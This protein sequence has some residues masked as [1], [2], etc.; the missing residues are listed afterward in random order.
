MAVKSISQHISYLLLTC[1]KVEVPGLGCFQAS[2][3]NAIYDS[4][5]GLFYPS[6][7][8]IG[9]VAKAGASA[10]QLIESLKRR[11]NIDT[12]EAERLI[13]NFVTS[14]IYQLKKQH[15]CRLEGIGYLINYKDSLILKDTFWKNHK[16]P[17][18]TSLAI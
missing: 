3:E 9:F 7:I 1:R 16:M 5:D 12:K 17:S 18:L 4:A 15:F 11:L 2:Y 10:A 8:R 14:V 13:N 6:K